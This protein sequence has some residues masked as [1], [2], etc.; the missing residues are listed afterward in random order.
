[1]S[2][3]KNKIAMM[4]KLEEKSHYLQ[5]PQSSKMHNKVIIKDK[6]VEETDLQPK[7][8]KRVRGAP[9]STAR[10][11]ATKNIVKNYGKAICSFACSSMAKP[12]L[13][14]ILKKHQVEADNFLEFASKA[15]DTIESIN[16][17]RDVLLI[18]KKDDTQT[19]SLRKALAGIGEVFI[20][21]FSVNWIYSG[22]LTHKEPH[23]KARFKIL[24]RIRNP[25][26]FT[27]LRLRGENI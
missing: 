4:K 7:K 1:M 8:R 23:L 24:R 10:D 21:F 25:E 16:T 3:L 5:S 15:K 27:Y 9:V 26:S 18:T 13:G 20:K 2:I 22:R 14:P 6:P 19:V 17:F 12:Y 11:R